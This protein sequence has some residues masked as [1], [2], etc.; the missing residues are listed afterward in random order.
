MKSDIQRVLEIFSDEVISYSLQEGSDEECLGVV[1]ESQQ[2]MLGK[3]IA[4]VLTVLQGE[5]DTVS[6]QE[7]FLSMGMENFSGEKIVLY[8]PTVEYSERDDAKRE[9]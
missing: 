7:A 5:E 9:E 6:V 4:D 8:F 3:F 1:L 2:D